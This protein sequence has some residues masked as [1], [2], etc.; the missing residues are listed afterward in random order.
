MPERRSRSCC[1]GGMDVGSSDH[2]ADHIREVRCCGNRI[3]HPPKRDMNGCYGLTSAGSENE[4][5]RTC[6]NA[7]TT[8]RASR[9]G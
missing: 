9:L 6:L 8:L 3:L 5:I 1:A 2:D 7:G 4:E